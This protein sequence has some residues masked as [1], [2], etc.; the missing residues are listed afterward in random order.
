[1]P[2]NVV[3]ITLNYNQ[4]HYTTKCVKSILQ[5]N[6]DAFKVVLVDNGSTHA[7]FTELEKEVTKI[8]DDRI[9]LHRIEENCGYVGGVNHGLN[10]G[11]EYRP[12]YYLILNNDTVIDKEA[13]THLVNCSKRYNNNA[14][15]TGK[16]YHYDSPNKLQYVGSR[17][18]NKTLLDYTALGYNEDDTGQFDEERR[19]D[20]LDDIFWLF[21]DKVYE[22]VGNYSEDFFFNGES[23]DYCLRAQNKGV[24]LIYTPN[25]KIWHKGSISIG[26]RRRNATQSYWVLKS[27]LILRYKYLGEKYFREYYRRAFYKAIIKRF[28]ISILK[29][30]KADI[31]GFKILFANHRAINDFN[32]WKKKYVRNNF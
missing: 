14:I 25:A 16:V 8:K 32:A 24:E 7:N 19:R 17:F 28:I 9:C 11:K 20:L 26:G 27:A 23:T 5:S 3:I 13:I 10:I 2:D 6:F 1:M 15:V 12:V 31:S 29:L 30:T 22:K 18:T 21:S 4:N